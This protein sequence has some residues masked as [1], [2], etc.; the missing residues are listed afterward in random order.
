MTARQPAGPDSPWP[1]LNPWR[2]HAPAGRERVAVRVRRQRRLFRVRAPKA[3]SRRHPQ[4]PNRATAATITT[5][6]SGFQPCAFRGVIRNGV[7]APFDEFPERA[8]G[9]RSAH[10]IRTAF[11]DPCIHAGTHMAFQD[12]KEVRH[13]RWWL[14]AL[15]AD[16]PR[17]DGRGP[18]GSGLSSHW[19]LRSLR[20]S[21]PTNSDSGTHAIRQAR[22]SVGRLWCLS[23]IAGGK[24]ED[25][26]GGPA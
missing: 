5:G 26:A 12:I 19:R 25:F 22:E 20:I 21:S 18:P 2:G 3:P 7:V 10:G 17:L 16:P 13:H 15:R 24:A 14:G 4:I 6:R 1:L 8:A 23:L 11:L 9:A